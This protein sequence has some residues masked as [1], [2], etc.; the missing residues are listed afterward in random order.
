MV[1]R[2]SG[3]VCHASTFEH[4]DLAGR[5]QTPELSNAGSAQA[6]RSGLEHALEI[7]R[8]KLDRV[9]GGADRL[10]L[11]WRGGGKG[12]PLSSASCN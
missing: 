9:L 1:G 4:E 6:S 3:R 8:C 10:P 5:D 7:P 11:A 12:E 2:L